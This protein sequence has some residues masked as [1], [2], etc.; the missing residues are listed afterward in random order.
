MGPI[1]NVR[2]KILL[3]DRCPGENPRMAASC[4]FGISK[5]SLSEFPV[6]AERRL[7]I[8]IPF[9]VDYGFGSIMACESSSM[10][11]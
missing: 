11:R 6:L 2:K 1:E 10:C 5:R 4:N 8:I 9:G 3:L 7:L